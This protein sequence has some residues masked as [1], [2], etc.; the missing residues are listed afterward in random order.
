MAKKISMKD[1]AN[2]VGVSTALVSYVLNGL[3]K[4]KRVGQEVVEKIRKVAKEL[5]YQPNQIAR[6]LRKGISNT[7]GLIVADIS[8]PFFGQLARVIEDEAAKYNYTVIFGSSDENCSKSSVLMEALLNR[9]VDG[10]LIVPTEGCSGQIQSLIKREIPVVLIDRF[11]PDVLTS[12]VVLD[13]YSATYSAVNCFLSKGHKKI[14]MIA[15]KSSLIHMQERIRGYQEAMKDNGLTNEILIK[16][17]RYNNV[18]NDLIK[19]MDDLLANKNMNALLFATNALSVHGLYAMRKSRI[20]IPE[21][22]AVIGFDGHEVFDF[23][24][25]PISY[26]KQPLEDMGKESVK[27]LL[28][29]IKGIKKIA[30]T[31]LKHQLIETA[32]IGQKIQ[33]NA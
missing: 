23:F 8:N 28:D 27:I 18:K 33:N 5:K 25:P 14:K 30:H 6:S 11:F 20:K 1:I 13:N 32:S 10:L 29:Q 24:Q 22:L 15:Y 2:K 17:V 7:L 9:Q 21:D 19:I 31:K 3:E 26:I 12:Y 4:E 16:E